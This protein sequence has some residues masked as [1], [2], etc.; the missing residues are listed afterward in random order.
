MALIAGITCPSP[1]AG[2]ATMSAW[3][4][5]GKEAATLIPGD[6]NA[7]TTRVL[8]TVHDD[9]AQAKRDLLLGA[10]EALTGIG[11]TSTLQ[12]VP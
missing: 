4:P 12:T 2:V 5:L 10:N 6:A 1:V 9:E 3:L 11:F 7:R 8:M